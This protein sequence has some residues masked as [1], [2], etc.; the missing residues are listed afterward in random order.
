MFE[1]IKYLI[2]VRLGSSIVLDDLFLAGN[3]FIKIDSAHLLT[4]VFFLRSDPDTRLNVLDDIFVLDSS[5]L[6]WSKPVSPTG[7]CNEVIYQFKSL[8]LPYRISLVIDSVDNALSIP[9]L[10]QLYSGAAWCEEDIRL[11]H[12]I[13]FEEMDMSHA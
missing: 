1:S 2:D 10:L 3:H 12:N 7:Q 6:P 9:S 11:S 8:V 5:F 4:T 13:D